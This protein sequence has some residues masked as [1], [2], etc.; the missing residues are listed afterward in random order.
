LQAPFAKGERD[1]PSAHRSVG[2]GSAKQCHG[3]PIEVGTP[4]VIAAARPHPNQITVEARERPVSLAQRF[5]ML[6]Q[7]AKSLELC[8]TYGLARD[9]EMLRD[10]LLRHAA[11]GHTR[12]GLGRGDSEHDGRRHSPA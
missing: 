2:A 9:A 12:L 10:L 11:I 8:L 5:E 1:R 6:T 7:L 4:L 3:L